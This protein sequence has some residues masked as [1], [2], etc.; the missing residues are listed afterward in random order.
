MTAHLPS[1][2]PHIVLDGLYARRPRG[3]IS[4]TFRVESLKLENF[5]DGCS[6]EQAGLHSPFDFAGLALIHTT[7]G[8]VADSP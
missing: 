2:D 6:R 5:S 1:L 8:R 3:R 4:L 7:H